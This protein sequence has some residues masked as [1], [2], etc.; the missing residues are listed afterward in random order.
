MEEL[1]SGYVRLLNMD[2]RMARP[3]LSNATLIDPDEGYPSFSDVEEQNLVPAAVRVPEA[4][5]SDS[6]PDERRPSTISWGGVT[7]FG[8]PPMNHLRK[9][10]GGSSESSSGERSA[11]SL[12]VPKSNYS[13]SDSENS[14]STIASLRKQ[15]LLAERRQQ[16]SGAA[17]S[18]SGLPYS[19]F[20]Q[21]AVRS[22]GGSSDQLY[23]TKH[24]LSSTAF[25]DNFSVVFADMM[26][27][28]LGFLPIWTDE[29]TVCGAAISVKTT[30][31]KL[32]ITPTVRCT[33]PGNWPEK[34]VEWILR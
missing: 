34:A 3:R 27:K 29:A 17:A 9:T 12:S 6:D 8:G 26:S 16:L 1:I 18:K 28:D 22:Y 20:A 25:M 13:N 2:P 33:S 31:A 15:Q 11:G 10:P 19:C 4:T 24:Y 7:A 32:E 14:Y 21:R 30:S 5:S 23:R